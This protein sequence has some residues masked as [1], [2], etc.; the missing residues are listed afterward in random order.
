MTYLDVGVQVVYVSLDGPVIY[1]S[2]FNPVSV[3]SIALYDEFY[4]NLGDLFEVSLSR[5]YSFTEFGTPINYTLV[6]TVDPDGW[7]T[8]DGSMND[9]MSTISPDNFEALGDVSIMDEAATFDITL[10]IPEEDAMMR[11]NSSEPGDG[12]KFG[13]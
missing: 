5:M 9:T 4:S 8:V 6:F 10:L 11:F 7:I 12:V 1:A 2:G 13:G 3:M